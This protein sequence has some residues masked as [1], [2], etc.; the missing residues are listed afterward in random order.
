M[1]QSHTDELIVFCDSWLSAWTGNQP[2]RLL[3]FYDEKA[4]YRD[5]GRPKGLRGHEELKAYFQK[6][7][8]ANPDWRWRAIEM[9]PTPKGFVLKWEATI[10]RGETVLSE[11]G[12]DIVEVREGKIVRNEVFFDSSRLKG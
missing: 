12:L 4:F 9:I 11:Q 2:E 3:S 6:L 1:P 8:A 7:L 5:P 10:P